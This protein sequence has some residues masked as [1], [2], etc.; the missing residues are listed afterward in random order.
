MLDPLDRVVAELEL[1]LIVENVVDDAL[2]PHLLVSLAPVPQG[3]VLKIEVVLI[4][5][6]LVLLARG[7]LV[8]G[9]HRPEP[10]T[11][12]KLGYVMAVRRQ[13]EPLVVHKM[14]LDTEF[15]GV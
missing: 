6:P 10:H 8:A 15:A 12:L 9:P 13:V 5:L 1:L 11:Q 4:E 7:D 2:Q 14:G 3:Q